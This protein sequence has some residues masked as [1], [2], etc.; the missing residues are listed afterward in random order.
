MARTARPP[1]MKS[2]MGFFIRDSMPESP[3]WWIVPAALP[4]RGAHSRLSFEEMGSTSGS[5]GADE[6]VI[7]GELENGYAVA[8]ILLAAQTDPPR[9]PEGLRF[10]RVRALVDTGATNLALSRVL[11]QRLGFLAMRT[12]SVQT[13]ASSSVRASF[14]HGVIHVPDPT[15]SIGA[16]FPCWVGEGSPPRGYDAVLGMEELTHG[17]LTVDGPEESWEWRLPRGDAPRRGT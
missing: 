6:V 13:A 14:G 12:V 4:V 9:Q 8:E 10:E 15:G 17:T 1:A 16:R 5:S 11:F 7:G 2:R 3:S